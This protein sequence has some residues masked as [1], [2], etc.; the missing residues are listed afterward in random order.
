[1][2]N[3]YSYGNWETCF[4]CQNPRAIC[5]YSTTNI[6]NRTLTYVIELFYTEYGVYS[7]YIYTL[8]RRLPQKCM[9]V[10][11]VPYIVRTTKPPAPMICEV[12]EKFR[13][14]ILYSFELL[15]FQQEAVSQHQLKVMISGDEHRDS[16]VVSHILP[17]C[18]W[19]SLF[20][21]FFFCSS[22]RAP[23]L[24]LYSVPESTYRTFFFFSF[25][26]LGSPKNLS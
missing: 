4:S 5:H 9:R 6:K 7:V 10:Y 12:A 22:A 21:L 11:S 8:T 1:M 17:S 24:C 14:A 16:G 13:L 2:E 19:K 18:F 15:E 25:P 23:I 26:T 20:S 3:C